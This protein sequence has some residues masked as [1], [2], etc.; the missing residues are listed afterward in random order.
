MTT[1]KS[2]HQGDV[3]FYPLEMWGKSEKDISRKTQ[4]NWG[5]RVTHESTIKTDFSK[6]LHE[7][8]DYSPET[9]EFTWRKTMGG[10]AIAGSIA[11]CPNSAGYV[12]IRIDKVKYQRSRL[13]WAYVHGA[14]PHSD[15]D[16]IDGNRQNDR[17]SNLRLAT[18]QE[19]KRNSLAPS[20]SVSGVKGVFWNSK[21]S[22][23]Q[24]RICISDNP[25]SR[26][27]LGYFHDLEE[28]KAAVVSASNEYFGKFSP[29]KS[30]TIP[31]LII[32]SGERTGHHHGVWFM[33][34]PVHL[35]ET[36]H[37]QAMAI[38]N[39][40]L[41]KAQRG[42]LAPARLYQDDDLRAALKLDA[43]APVIGFLFCEEDVTIQHA[44]AEGIPT[45]E[46]SDI[47]LPAGGYLVTGKREWTAGDERRI[48][49]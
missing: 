34:R 14:M 20:N 29:Y 27:H 22:K 45:H 6:R 4:L 11:G 32:Q 13:A 39:D 1:L 30:R 35:M 26:K 18:R 17:I 24:A 15:I 37:G 41:V 42:E 12:L 47:K 9:G 23:W 7:L 46:H 36:G 33:P 40:I 10:F 16:H 44:S 2:Y 31:P 3:N 19:N 21:R 48:A 38:A 28:A 8:L 25:P 5:N 49:D 43:G